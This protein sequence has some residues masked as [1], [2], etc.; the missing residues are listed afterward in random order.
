[1]LRKARECRA[2]PVSARNHG[3]VFFPFRSST[4]GPERVINTFRYTQIGP[5]NFDPCTKPPATP[6]LTGLSVASLIHSREEAAAGTTRGYLGRVV[7]VHM[8]TQGFKLKNSWP[9]G[10]T[11]VILALW[12]QRRRIF[13]SV[14]LVYIVRPCPKHTH[15]LRNQKR[16]VELEGWWGG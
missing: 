3:I 7:C 5:I 10:C 8:K 6:S 15:S 4:I 16:S 9:W 12:R 13:I 14:S 2:E 1:M 11:L